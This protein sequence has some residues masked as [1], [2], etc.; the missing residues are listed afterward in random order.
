MLWVR[1]PTLKP[2]SI[3]DGPE[4]PV[5]VPES[6]MTRPRYSAPKP[7]ISVPVLES[8][9]LGLETPVPVLGSLVP[10]PRS[11]KAEAWKPSVRARDM[12]FVDPGLGVRT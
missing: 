10:K 1:S 6:L 5:L 4:T 9:M 11:I 12:A 2:C 3:E 7:E 8:L